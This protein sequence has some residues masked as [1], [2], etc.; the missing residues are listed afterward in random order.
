MRIWH[1]FLLSLC[2]SLHV[3]S[4]ETVLRVTEKKISIQGREASV[5]TIT[6]PDGTFGLYVNKGQPF[7]VKLENLLQ[8]PTSVHWHGL[9]LPN[10]QDGVA[11]ITQFAIYPGLAYNYKFPLV[12]EGTFWMHSH[13]NLQEQKL[14]SAPLILYGADDS[15]IADKEAVVLL[16]DFTFKSPTVI[17]QDLKC[18]QKAKMTSHQMAMQDIV[19]VDYDAYLA[20]YHTLDSPEII[21]VAPGS[22][23]RLRM[24][25]G[26]SATNFFLHLGELEGEAIAV[27]GN[28]IQPLKGSEFE[29]SI[30]QR[31]DILVTIPS[32]GGSFP[33]LAQGEGT[34]LQTGI[35]LLTK[36][37]KVPSLSSKASQKAG[38]L[39]NAQESKLHALNPLPEKPIDNKLTVELGGN[40][41]EYVWTLN[42]QSW[43]E[44]TPL[45]AE[46]GQRLEITFVNTSTM[47]H[48]MHLH[49][50]VFQ[51]TAIDGKPLNGAMRDT[52]LVMPKSS[53]SIQ[54]D[55]DNPG[56]WPL[57]CHVL[58]HMEA[59]MFT[60]LRYKDFI[61][62]L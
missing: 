56:V 7:D 17:F 4:V 54:F 9:I 39:T 50:H 44:V 29:L 59:G 30:A 18:N 14:L 24:I 3:S 41:Q 25:N 46:K 57:H 36:G 12:Q 27:D 33:I 60:V 10:N 16:T 20:N 2:F 5:F 31:I 42:G 26:S 35:I 58:Y 49:G 52:V 1:Y 34:S 11:F 55:A 21:E 53:L 47:S 15:K 28:K 22:K 62:P 61:Q 48:P 38:G 43:P 45:V 6:Q 32:Q 23:V 13:L 8:V 51:V 37:S 19:E 40:M